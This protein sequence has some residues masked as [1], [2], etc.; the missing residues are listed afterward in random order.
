MYTY[1]HEH[2]QKEQWALAFYIQ[3]KILHKFEVEN[4]KNNIY[5]I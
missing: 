2:G 1:E 4:V 5:K 3:N